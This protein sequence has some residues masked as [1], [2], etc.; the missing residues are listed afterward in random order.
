MKKLLFS[1]TLSL[2]LFFSVS[3]IIVN[4]ETVYDEVN[5]L[6][7]ENTTISLEWNS[8]YDYYYV[9]V[10]YEGSLEDLGDISDDLY[11][12]LLVNFK[13]FGD[14][15][16]TSDYGLVE[17]YFTGDTTTP[18]YSQDLMVLMGETNRHM[19]SSFWLDFY[20]GIVIYYNDDSYFEDFEDDLDFPFDRT[21]PTK[22]HFE[23]PLTVEF[24]GI[25]NPT[26]YLELWVEY[27]KFTFV[28]KTA[29]M[30]FYS[31]GYTDTIYDKRYIG[32]T[33]DWIPFPVQNPNREGYVFNNWLDSNAEIFE[34]TE[35]G[36]TN[37]W[38][39]TPYTKIVISADY[40]LYTGGG[41]NFEGDVEDLPS[42]ISNFI[43]AIGFDNYTG[44][45]IIFFIINI[46]IILVSVLL[47]FNVL[48]PL[49]LSFL[50]FLA[51][52]I[53]G[54]FPVFTILIMLAIYL[55]IFGSREFKVGDS[56]E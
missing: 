39:T 36:V 16:E 6:E 10:L 56:S 18:T 37:Y 8:T 14:D 11:L 24:G 1:I 53:F 42:G 38:D 46:I 28:N 5:L 13:Y 35:E 17:I 4:A 2:I 30:T 32:D 47:K 55:L 49:F 15:D 26:T 22:I 44:Y 41:S 7:H 54:L 33:E 23:I 25:P 52:S 31:V 43:S 19:D 27:H 51:F 29:G 3:F 12:D 34:F 9:D 21:L 45:M 20:E 48:A 40:T 50:I